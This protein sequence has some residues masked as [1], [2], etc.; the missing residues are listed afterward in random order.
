MEPPQPMDTSSDEERAVDKIFV[1]IC[2]FC[3]GGFVIPI[4]Y[5]SHL[6]GHIAF[7]SDRNIFKCSICDKTD[8][9]LTLIATHVEKRHSVKKSIP[10]ESTEAKRLIDRNVAE[11]EEM[12]SI[13]ARC[14]DSSKNFWLPY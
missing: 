6:S 10:L 7:H 9:N 1:L 8:R 5:I 13:L 2:P 12:I 3:T 11:K 4:V 14:N